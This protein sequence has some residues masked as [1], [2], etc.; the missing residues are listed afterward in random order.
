MLKRSRFR[1]FIILLTAM[2]LMLAPVAGVYGQ[3]GSPGVIQ[4]NELVIT[5]LGDNGQIE[6]IQVLNNLHFAGGGVSTIE[7]G[8]NYSVT[9]VRNLYSTQ[10]IGQKD[11]S[12]SVKTSGTAEDLY[13]LASI[14]KKEIPRIKMPV[15]VQVDYFLDGQKVKPSNIYGKSGHLKIVCNLENTTGVEQEI[16]YQ[17]SKGNLAKKQATVFTPYVVSLSGWEFDNRKFSNIK[18]PGVAGES[19][20]GVMVNVQGIT[21]VNWSVPLVPPKYPAKQYTVLE[22]D[23]KHMELPS[24]KIA[25]IPIVPTTAEIDNIPT[26]HESFLKLYDG[27]DQI[28]N[29]VGAREKDATLLFGLGAVKDG[30]E[31]LSGGLGSLIDKMKLIRFGIANPAFNAATY[32]ADKGAD[33]KGNTPGLRDAVG[34][35]KAGV[36]ERA[37]PAYKLQAMILGMLEQSIGKSGEAVQEPNESTTIMNDVAYLKS[38]VPA[39]QQKIISDTIEPKLNRLAKNISVFSNGG[40]ILT[41]SGSMPF[42]ASVKA[43]E[44]GSTSTLAA[45]NKIDGG[46]AM[47]ELGMGPVDKNGKPVKVM[48]NGQPGTIL[49]ALAYMQESIDGQLVPGITKLQDGAGKIG[50]GA[51][52]AKEAISGGLAT[53]ES[54]PAIVSALQENA[55]KADT[56]LGKPEGATGTVAYV[57]QTPEVSKE[58]NAMKYGLGALAVVLILLIALGR[59]PKQAFEAPVEHA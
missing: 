21:Q 58:A 34:L 26:I 45:L 28:Q 2:M 46:L 42:P 51:G 12:L 41:S 56:F 13:Y 44:E 59:P 1:N 15:S 9:S 6:S 24:F 47:M 38:Q 11:N 16:E 48:M 55:G 22:A 33:A 49:Y 36:E 37:L 18:A 54:V 50:T 19:P 43:L 32:N 27:F 5:Q 40:N 10:K 39:P 25:I 53:F 14:D 4:D 23:G 3:D 29:G 20:E 35:L 7:D 31:K 57:F 52:T 30:A 8:K 17:D